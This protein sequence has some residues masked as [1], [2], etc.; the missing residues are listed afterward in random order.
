MELMK[1]RQSTPNK[2]QEQSI[3]KFIGEESPKRKTDEE[4]GEYI[5]TTKVV[6][7]GRIETGTSAKDEIET[8]WNKCPSQGR[9][10]NTL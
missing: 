8:L 2:E 7:R 9:N 6:E 10:R 4:G 3:K 5:R 1:N